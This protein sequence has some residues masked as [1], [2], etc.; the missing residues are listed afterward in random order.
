M[1]VNP[2]LAELTALVIDGAS[3]PGRIVSSRLSAAGA[4][5]AI[6]TVSDGGSAAYLS[7]ELSGL[8]LTALPYQVDPADRGSM[9]QLLADVTQD[10]GRLDVLVNLLPAPVDEGRAAEERVQLRT[11]LLDVLAT[12]CRGGRLILL[13]G[14]APPRLGS[15]AEVW[16]DTVP[17]PAPLPNGWAD[18]GVPASVHHS[19]ANAVLLLLGIPAAAGA[20]I[21]ATGPAELWG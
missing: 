18:P 2:P 7:K 12:A 16:V 4:R 17:L 20:E 9:E 1:S 13:A 5:V 15:L 14:A 8:G 19:T 6:V 10:L 3:G 21:D 11:A